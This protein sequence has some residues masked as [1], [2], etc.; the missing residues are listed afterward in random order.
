M[1]SRCSIC[2]HPERASID[3]SVL[4]DG[5]RLTARQFQVSRPSLDRHKR[6]LSQIVAAD[7]AQVVA[8]SNDGA[9]PL[10]SRLDVM[11]R[12]CE[13]ALSQ[14]QANKNFSGAMRAIRELR[15]YFELKCKLESDERKHR[16]LPKD[17]PEQKSRASDGLQRPTLDARDSL[18]A[19]TLRIRIRLAREELGETAMITE[20]NNLEYLQEQYTAL[21]ARLEQRKL[22]KQ[23]EGLGSIPTC[24]D[25]SVA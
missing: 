11:I 8:T 9:I 20:P 1:M 21:S 3:V 19:T 10:P 7:Q 16:G 18:R 24:N 14:A 4:R 12:H 5:T 23:S 22:L 15:A 6:H 17:F 25:R 2:R 13:S